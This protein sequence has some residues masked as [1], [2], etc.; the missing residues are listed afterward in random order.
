MK[1]QTMKKVR[2][3]Y[4][5]TSIGGWIFLFLMPAEWRIWTD[6]HNNL[7]TAFFFYCTPMFAVGMLIALG[8]GLFAVVGM[9]GCIFSVLEGR[10]I[11]KDTE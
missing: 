5:V 3:I 1:A 8:L 7:F 10:N 2:I 6:Q 4:F 9:I 11:F